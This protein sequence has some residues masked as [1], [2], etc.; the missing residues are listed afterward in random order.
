MKSNG[1]QYA[2]ILAG[3]LAVLLMPQLVQAA[4]INRIFGSAYITGTIRTGEY[5][6]VTQDFADGF[7]KGLN[8]KIDPDSAPFETMRI[9]LWLR[10]RQP[11]LRV[12]GHC[13]GPCASFV[14][15]SGASVRIEPGLV[16][17]FNMQTEWAAMIR[18]RVNAGEL[19][20][21][22]E[23]SQLS[24]AHLLRG[25]LKD[26]ADQS[27]LMRDAAN[28]LIPSQGLQFLRDLTLSIQWN[29][30]RFDEQL[31]T[32]N[33]RLTPG[34]CWWWVPDAEGLRQLGVDAPGYQPASREAAAKLLKTTPSMIYIGPVR[35][36]M[37][38]EGFCRA[39]ESQ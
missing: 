2:G 18:D 11:A 28:R 12:R 9:G 1:M 10:E 24:R 35:E 37:P 30:V 27:A 13:V 7:P 32:F 14:L 25:P 19:F 3:V 15:T 33:F 26:A 29:K 17:A 8:I 6:E 16:I 38:E 39:P 4:A 36:Q 31:A 5:E 22:D 23:R 21:D 20:I 34:R